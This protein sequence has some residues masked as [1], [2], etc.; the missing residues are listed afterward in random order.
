V[1]PE[2]IETIARSEV[3]GDNVVEVRRDAARYTT[4]TFEAFGLIE[5]GVEELSLELECDA[6]GDVMSNCRVGR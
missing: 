1:P 5:A 3:H 6:T 2:R 4:P